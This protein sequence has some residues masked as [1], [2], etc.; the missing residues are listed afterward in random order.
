MPKYTVHLMRSVMEWTDVE[1]ADEK[2]AIAL[3]DVEPMR[4]IYSD[5]D[6]TQFLAI[7][8]YDGDGAT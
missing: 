3:C 2:A 4:S 7:E 5:G 6:P 8:E 1:A